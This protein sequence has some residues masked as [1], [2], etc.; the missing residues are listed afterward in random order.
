[1]IK[2]DSKWCSRDIF[3]RLYRDLLVFKCKV[4]RYA[5]ECNFIDV[6]KIYMAFPA[7]IVSKLSIIMCDLLYR[8]PPTSDSKC[9]RYG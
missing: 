3:H 7:P 9:G 6:S 1:M 2:Q 5:R 8:L 4:S